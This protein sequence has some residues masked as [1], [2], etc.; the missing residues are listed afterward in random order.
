MQ[1]ASAT[2][3]INHG[4]APADPSGNVL[5][6]FSAKDGTTAQDGDGRNSPFT[7]ALLR[8]L[9]QPGIEVTFLFRIVRDEVMKATGGGQQPYVYGSLPKDSIYLKPPTSD[10]LLATMPTIAPESRPSNAL[11][12][13]DDAKLVAELARRKQFNMPPF[14]IDALDNDVPDKLKRFLGIWVSK[15]GNGNGAG[16]Q[17]M[18]I[19]SH[20]DRDGT[21]SGYVMFGPPTR[22]A[23]N[24]APASYTAFKTTVTGNVLQ[25]QI[26]KTSGVF[27]LVSGDLFSIHVQAGP[28]SATNTLYP[29]WHLSDSAA[30]KTASAD[31]G[32][33]APSANG[34]PGREG[35]RERA[36]I[37]D[38]RAKKAGAGCVELGA[39]ARRNDQRPDRACR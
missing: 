33:G 29:V 16:K 18:L 19:V 3:S 9:E 34:S 37:A 21:V 32:N 31:A 6:A 26:N 39:A 13:A 15:I 2:R 23:W 8:H 30:G 36:I 35:A 22:R 38:G 11:F 7:S 17:M 12:T 20:V 28:R 25:F 24:Q 5:I 10:Q 14:Q 1:T 27:E 4:L